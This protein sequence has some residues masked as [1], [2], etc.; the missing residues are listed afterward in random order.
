MC[1]LPSCL[2]PSLSGSSRESLAE[3]FPPRTSEIEALGIAVLPA[4]RVAPPRI[5]DSPIHLEC[6]LSRI[7]PFGRA[8]DLLIA[9]EV[10]HIHIHDGIMADHKVDPAAWSPLGR[11]GGRRYCRVREFIDAGPV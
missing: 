1:S 10:V 4:I 2:P 3:P 6:R 11:I 5:L 7:V 8:P 9:G